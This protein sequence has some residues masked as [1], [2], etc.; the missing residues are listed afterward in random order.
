MERV[1]PKD[2]FK[3]DVV[4]Y[5]QQVRIRINPLLINKPVPYL[6]IDRSI[7]TVSHLPSIDTPKFPDYRKSS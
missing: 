1:N 4:H 6:D 3:G 2:G 5:G 7:S